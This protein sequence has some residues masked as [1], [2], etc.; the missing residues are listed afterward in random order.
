MS[1]SAVELTHRAMA[2][3]KAVAE[4]RAQMSRSCEPDLFIDGFAC[5]DQ[6]TAHA[7]AHGGYL[8]PAVEGA[9]GRVPAELTE[10]GRAALE[11]T[12]AA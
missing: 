2:M 7:L 11:V 3:L 4:G 6:I 9:T 10:A 1:G 8:R 12:A 5:C